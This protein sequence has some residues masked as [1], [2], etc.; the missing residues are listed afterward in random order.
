MLLRSTAPTLVRTASKTSK[1]AHSV[2]LANSHTLW[3]N[4][5]TMTN[6]EQIIGLE[7]PW[8]ALD[9]QFVDAATIRN[10]LDRVHAE[11]PI[12][13][14]WEDLLVPRFLSELDLRALTLRCESTPNLLDRESIIHP[15]YIGKISLGHKFGCWNMPTYVD[16]KNRARYPQMPS[17]YTANGTEGA[18]RV[19]YRALV[20]DIPEGNH[21]DHRCNNKCCVYPRHTEPTTH[22]ENT[23]RGHRDAK[24]RRQPGLFPP[25]V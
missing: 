24:A 2:P 17:K 25:L 7:Q 14:D 5:R 9:P 8:G 10:R 3:H 12:Q 1:P 21:I 23:R 13:T 20:G 18:H 6:R 16:A 15:R 4:H 19:F 22:E 11:G